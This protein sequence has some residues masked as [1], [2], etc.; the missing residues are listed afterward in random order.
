MSRLPI[1]LLAAALLP[2]LAGTSGAAPPTPVSELVVAGGPPPKVVTSFP[3][4][5][6]EVSAGVLV[7]KVVFDQAMKPDGWSYG[8][9]SGGEFPVCLARPRLLADQR[10]FVLLC[11]VAA[12]KSYA[13]QVNA[14]ADL[15]NAGGRVAKPSVLHFTTNDATVRNL[16]D[17]LSQA[18]L[19]EVDEPVMSWRDDG[20]A[21][22]G[23]PVAKPSAGGDPPSPP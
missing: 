11:T 5:S 7:M 12:H 9:T 1:P 17:A 3:A 20:V 13:V 19:T 18:S 23:A 4:D 6:T 21:P 14:A 2:T 22:W 16:H 8:P 15:T 10:T